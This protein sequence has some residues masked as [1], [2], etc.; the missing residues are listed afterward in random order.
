MPSLPQLNFLP[1]LVSVPSAFKKFYA[2]F[3]LH[4]FML[5]LEQ[6]IAKVC[7][8]FQRV[9]FIRFEE[10]RLES[11][12]YLLSKFQPLCKPG[13]SI[14]VINTVVSEER[15]DFQIPHDLQKN[16]P[17]HFKN[18]RILLK[19]KGSENRSQLIIATKFM[20]LYNLR[21]ILSDSQKS[22]QSLHVSRFKTRLKKGI[23]SLLQCKY[24]RA[25]LNV[26]LYKLY[27]IITR[28]L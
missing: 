5:Q 12:V 28:F 23:V 16:S 27:C 15:C 24:P 6:D 8:E 26:A 1:A 7:A 19:M 21:T 22:K 18:N 2:E 9:P 13:I 3:V 14:E 20:I 25:T 4:F 17:W 10:I 11:Q